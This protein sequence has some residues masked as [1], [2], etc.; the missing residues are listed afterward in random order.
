MGRFY[1]YLLKRANSFYYVGKGTGNRW[2]GSARERGAFEL[3]LQYFCCGEDEAF[4][5]EDKIYCEMS[6][7]GFLMLNQMRPGRHMKPDQI[8]GRKHSEATKV[9]MRKTKRLA[10]R[11]ITYN[12][13]TLTIREWAEKLDLRKYLIGA[14]LKRGWPPEKVL[15]LADRAFHN[16]SRATHILEFKGEKLLVSEWSERTRISKDIIRNRIKKGWSTERILTEPTLEQRFRGL[17][18]IAI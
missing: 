18:S 5:L 4:R 9:K 11:K 2:R 8:T 14:R 15:R 10:A 1:V 6:K 17:Q 7:R 13:E 3:R 16:K 12:G